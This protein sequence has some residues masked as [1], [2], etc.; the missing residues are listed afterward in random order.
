MRFLSVKTRKL[1]TYLIQ[2]QEPSH[3]S[4]IFVDINIVRMLRN[5]ITGL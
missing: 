2:L 3:T 1:F 4:A 5:N